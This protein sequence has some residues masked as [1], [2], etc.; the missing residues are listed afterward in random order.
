MTITRI[1]RRTLTCIRVTS[2]MRLRIRVKKIVRIMKRKM[3]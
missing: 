3:S 1:T 2:S